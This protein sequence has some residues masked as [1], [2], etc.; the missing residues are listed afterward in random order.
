M[1]KVD[2]KLLKK[3]SNGKNFNSFIDEFDRTTN[4]ENKEKVVKEL[5]TFCW[6]LCS[7]GWWGDDYSEYKCKLFDIINAVDYFLCEYPKKMSEWLGRRNQSKLLN[8]L[9]N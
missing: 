3:Y 5:E 6:A 7:T 8:T 1:G 2:D 4:E 9:C